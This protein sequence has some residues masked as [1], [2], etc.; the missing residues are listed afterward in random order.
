MKSRFCQLKHAARAAVAA[1][2]L[3]SSQLYAAPMFSDIYVFGDSLSDTGNTRAAVP[4]G[5]TGTVAALAGY[6][7][8]GRFSNGPVWHEYLADLLD[9][10]RATRSSAGGN[11]YAYGGARVDNAVGFS[12]G[13]LTQQARY[14]NDLGGGPSD[15]DAL[16]VAWAGGNDMRDLVGDADPLAAINATL[17]SLFGVLGGLVASGAGTLLVP[18]L[19]DLGSIPEFRTSAEAASATF[20]TTAW[21]TGLEQR[22]NGLARTTT[23]SIYFLDVFSV[24]NSILADPAPFGYT[25]TTDECRSVVSSGFLGLGRTEVSCA[26]ADGYL[27][28][29]QIHPTTAAHR[30]LGLSAFALLSSGA[31]LGT[32]PTPMTLWLFLFGLL[33]LALVHRRHLASA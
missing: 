1:L 18:N 19:P 8:N 32:V 31:A 21:N 15:S 24:F 2:A 7:P 25:N 29:D 16:F 20:V 9:L 14:N 33:I 22:L 5:S 23:A 27:F 17:D 11:N 28:W 13:V 3:A 30:A 4:L 6:G 26:G 12:A 10:P